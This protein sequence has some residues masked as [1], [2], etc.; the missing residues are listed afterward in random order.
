MSGLDWQGAIADIKGAVKALKEL[1]GCTKVGLIGLCM[2]SAL[3]IASA[4]VL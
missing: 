4:T 2:G 1:K 3:S